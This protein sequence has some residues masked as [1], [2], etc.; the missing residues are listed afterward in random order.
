MHADGWVILSFVTIACGYAFGVR[1]PKTIKSGAV[2]TKTWRDERAAAVRATLIVSPD[3][4]H[5]PSGNR[6]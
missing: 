3:Y 4:G 2:T 5:H 1:V 6:S